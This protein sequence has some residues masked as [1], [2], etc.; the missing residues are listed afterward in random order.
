MGA[1][2]NSNIHLSRTPMDAFKGV[3]RRV[4][5]SVFSLSLYST[6]NVWNG[7]GNCRE[8]SNCI[9]VILMPNN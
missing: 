7:I 9:K 2:E 1:S 3:V 4:E 6:L 5:P 8:M